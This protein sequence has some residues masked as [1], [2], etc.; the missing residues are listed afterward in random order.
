MKSSAVAPVIGV[1]ACY[2]I[3]PD[4]PYHA[5]QEKY[6]AAVMDAAGALPVILPA[7]GAAMADPALL[8]RLDGLLLTGAHSN[9]E[10]HHYGAADE[11]PQAPRDRQRDATTIA[12]VRKARELKLPIFAICR[13]FQEVN[14]ALGGTLHQRLHMLKG[15]MDHRSDDTAA[16]AH[17][18][19]P[20]HSLQLRSGGVLASL[21]QERGV[22]DKEGEIMVNSLHGQGIDR[23]APPLR[24]EAV[25]KDGTIEAFSATEGGWLL[26]VQWH[27]EYN[28]MN[29]EV[30]KALFAAFAAAARARQLEKG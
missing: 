19:G 10:P 26:G 15:R 13:G 11:E 22:L 18:Y 9:I 5:V 3:W 30:S 8:S 23:L 7:K 16:K 27:P 24:V 17:Q 14:I 29:N 6:I 20:V 21:L 1:S 25:A 4:W 12:L 28:A 2:K